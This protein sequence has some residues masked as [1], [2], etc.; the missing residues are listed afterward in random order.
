MTDKLCYY[1][2]SKNVDAGKGSNEFVNDPAIYSELNKIDNWRKKLSNFYTEP[3]TYEGKR[4]NS[5]EHAFQSYKIALVSKEKAEYFT[6]DSNHPIGQGDGSV[7][8]KNRKLVVLDNEQLKTWDG[9]KHDLMKNISLQRI[10]QSDI[11]KN[12]LL[13]TGKAELWHVVVR[14]GIVRNKYLEELRDSFI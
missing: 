13:M 4:Y 3:F 12:I 1:S 8:Q 9:I 10:L 14:K 7:A 11:Y 2:K 6:L 5:V